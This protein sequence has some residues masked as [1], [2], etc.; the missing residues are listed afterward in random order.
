MC[1]GIHATASFSEEMKSGSYI[2][3]YKRNNG[4]INCGVTIGKELRD[5][6]RILA[7]TRHR[8]CASVRGS[9][10]RDIERMQWTQSIDLDSNPR[11]PPSLAL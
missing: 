1:K 5:V 8:I 6:E 10:K 7:K 3:A 9:K 2:N 11:L 4:Q